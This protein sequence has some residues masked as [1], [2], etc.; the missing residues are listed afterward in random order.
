MITNLW[1]GLTVATHTWVVSSSCEAREA[2]SGS[3]AHSSSVEPLV[4]TL[5]SWL[6]TS[7]FRVSGSDSHVTNRPKPED[8]RG[9]RKSKN[10]HLLTLDP[11]KH[12]LVSSNS[13]GNE[14]EKKCNY[15]VNAKS[16]F[17]CATVMSPILRQWLLR[18]SQV[19]SH[20]CLKVH[21]HE[22]LC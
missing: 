7:W 21:N 16:Q 17:V 13:T 22:H 9:E 5:S 12:P 11:I 2:W 3:E 8:G 10:T 6:T 18:V 19:W 15:K 14:R 20:R 4:E 1:S